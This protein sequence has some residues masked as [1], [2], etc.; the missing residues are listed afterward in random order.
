MAH[1]SPRQLVL[2]DVGYVMNNVGPPFQGE[3]HVVFLMILG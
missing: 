2:L 1:I 3:K